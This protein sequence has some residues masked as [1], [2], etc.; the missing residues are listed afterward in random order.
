MIVAPSH[1]ERIAPS[2]DTRFA[3]TTKFY[4][5]GGRLEVHQW[6]TDITS[7]QLGC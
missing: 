4:P 3:G 5:H 6:P 1:S 2:T 7:G